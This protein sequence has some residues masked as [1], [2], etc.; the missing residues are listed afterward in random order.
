MD[1]IVPVRTF[2][3]ENMAKHIVEYKL[4]GGAVPYFIYDGGYAPVGGKL[5]GITKDDT[6]CYIPSLVADGGDLVGLTNQQVIDRF[7]SIK[8]ADQTVEQATAAAQAWLT[9]KGF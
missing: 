9:S 2:K 7:V 4:H 1:M 8:S 3:G 5:I 6:D